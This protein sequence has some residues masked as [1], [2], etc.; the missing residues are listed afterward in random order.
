MYDGSRIFMDV[1][2]ATQLGTWSGWIETPDHRFEI[3]PSF[4]G[5]KDRSWGVR[6]VGEPL[7]G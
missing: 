4:R 1:T 6:P 3:T 7:P 2:R 5:T